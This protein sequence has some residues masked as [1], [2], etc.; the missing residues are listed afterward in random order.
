MRGADPPRAPWDIYIKNSK[1][2]KGTTVEIHT[3]EDKGIK[4]TT[5]RRVGGVEKE[6]KA[7]TKE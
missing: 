6:K 5:E 7:R 1:E 4:K 3:C 2:I